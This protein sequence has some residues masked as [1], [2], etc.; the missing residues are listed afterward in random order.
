MSPVP[1]ALSFAD[2]PSVLTDCVSKSTLRVVAHELLHNYDIKNIYY[3]PS[4]EVF[5]WAASLNSDYWGSDDG[6][7]FHVSSDKVKTVMDSFVNTF[8]IIS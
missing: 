6:S 8:S 2:E 7:E 1:V 5:R 4:F 3:W